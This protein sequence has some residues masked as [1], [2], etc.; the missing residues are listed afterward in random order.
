MLVPARSPLIP[1]AAR[2]S[3]R[4]NSEIKVDLTVETLGRYLN[5]RL[6]NLAM[7]RLVEPAS[8]ERR[9]RRGRRPKALGNPRDDILRAALI[10]FGLLGFDGASMR[11]IA[12]KAGTN[13]A[14]T[15]HYFGNKERLFRETLSQ[16]MRA[17][18]SAPPTTI[19]DPFR[20]AQAI[21]KLFLARWENPGY[22]YGFFR[23]AAIRPN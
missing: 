11:A 17:P 22:S 23:I 7:T 2:K 14:L 16:M 5:V 12:S 21:V 9:L 15:Y 1:K 18:E 3:T 8:S 13:P 4:S 10:E 19:K 20:A 6:I